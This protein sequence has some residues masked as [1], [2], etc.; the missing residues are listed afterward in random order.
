RP[1]HQPLYLGSLKSNIG[2]TQ[3]AAGVSGV[4]KMVQ[5]IR[6][7]TVPGTLHMTELSRHVDWSAGTVAVPSDAV[8]WPETGRPRRAGVSSFGISG[9]N[10]HLIVE[11][12]PAVEEPARAASGVVVPWVLS[13]RTD[14]AV[15]EQAA[16]LAERVTQSPEIDLASVGLTLA[17][18]RS[19]FERGA[20]VVG[21]DRE[22]LL[23]ALSEVT[24]GRT[25]L[26]ARAGSGVAMLFAG[27]GGQRV[28]MG[29]ELYAAHPVFATAVDD[30]LTAVDKELA[31]FVDHPVRDVLFDTTD[32]GLLDQTVYTQS[33]LFAIEVGLYRLLESWGVRPAWLVGH[34]IGE[35]AAAHVAGVF[36]LEDA[37]RLIAARGRLMQAL[38]DGGVMAAIE[39]T[40]AEVVPLLDN[41]V[42][43]A[44]V[45]G[46][47]SVV[48]SGEHTAVERV[49]AH[50][51]NAGH[52]VKRLKVS[53]AFHSPLME[54]MLDDFAEVV[55]SLTFHAPSIPIVSTVTGLAV[56]PDTLTD[57]AYWV[58]H[59]R[60]TVRF[61]DA[62]THLA[63]HH[64][65]GYVEIGPSGVLVAQTQ[66]ILD[67]KGREGH[68]VLPTL[69][70]GQAETHT[71]LT[72]LGRLYA[73]GTGITP[74]WQTILGNHTPLTDLPTY[75]FQRQRYWL[76]ASDPTAD[77]AALGLAPLGHTFLHGGVE[78]AGGEGAV[79][80]GRFSLDSH[81]W[82]VDHTVLGRVLLPGTAFVELALRAAD[83]M[84][85]ARVE[86]LTLSAPLIVPTDGDVQVQVSVGAADERGGRSLTVHARDDGGEWT[87]HAEGM[88]GAGAVAPA[89]AQ[90][91][92]PPPE[93]VAVDVEALYDTLLSGGYAYGPAF[94]GLRAVWRA[95]D[96]LLAEV[97]LP[98]GSPEG[99]GLHPVLL[100][101][102]LHP[103]VGLAL[104]GEEPTVRLPFAWTGAT[105]HATGASELRVRITPDGEGAGGV[106]ISAVDPAGAPVVSVR[107]LRLLPVPLDR[108]EAA[109]RAVPYRV[110]WLPSDTTATEAATR[111]T[112]S[113]VLI[114]EGA[115]AGLPEVPVHRGLG[116][117]GD[118]APE[119]V[120]FDARGGLD[121]SGADDDRLVADMHAAVAGASGFLWSWLADE[122]YAES[123][124]VV[125]TRGAVA[126]GEGDVPDLSTAP[127][128]GLVRS[129]QAEHPG[130]IVLLDVDGHAATPAA[131]V[132][133]V[134][135]GEPQLAVRAGSVL[136]PRLVRAKPREGEQ[137]AGLSPTGTVLITGGT[138]T[139]GAL[140]AR[141]LV[142]RH[143]ARHLL[144]T[145]RRGP[146]AP[147]ATELAAE[148]TELGAHV[149]I[150]ACDVAD[151]DELAALLAGVPEEHPLTAVV[152]AAGVLAD[153]AFA[154]LTDETFATVLRPKADAAWNLHRLTA[155]ADLAAFFLFSSAVGVMGNAGQ[156]NYGSAN[157]FLDALAQYRA[158]HGLPA[159][160]AAWGLWADEGGMTEAMTQA[161]V[162]RMGRRGL[163]AMST[164]RGL[165][166]F[167]TA[168]TDRDPF[169]VTAVVDTAAWDP[170]S[171]SPV[172]RSLVRGRRRPEAASGAAP[173]RPLEQDLVGR[174]AEEQHDVLLD[175]VRRTAAGVLGHGS[176]DAVPPRTGFLEGG[177][178]SLGAVELRT[179]LN[180]ATGL[181][182]PTTLIFDYPTPDAVADY[183][184]TRL[185]GETTVSVMAELERFEAVVAALASATEGGAERAAVAGRLGE[186]LRRLDSEAEAEISAATNDELFALIDEELQL[187]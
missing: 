95:G 125:V 50:F 107:S 139:L 182:L 19:R 185:V 152:H 3:A 154:S 92:W 59:V 119:V 170:E 133:A 166:L 144:L 42:G 10:A 16:R 113:W 161:D 105:L 45:N 56:E 20:V 97:V 147:G 98:E 160:A 116:A 162:V 141:R 77:A 138:G 115:G 157:S 140:V 1:A 79:L 137:E 146:E 76:N 110:D 94:R 23:T 134:A 9:T 63:D 120:L 81:P 159:T 43:I 66:Q 61:H 67:A 183:L 25:P 122:R 174:P 177:F 71:T 164:A 31:G 130:R 123:T 129:V 49:T 90:G 28:E 167:D 58:H 165:D 124:L 60:T 38:P 70:P 47:A 142:T 4:I 54:P 93:A 187:P 96:E 32:T 27:Q 109:D 73:A 91:S 145:G 62:I 21:A 64:T 18:A 178:D 150:A 114:G 179:R 106:T 117:L 102:A 24:D 12:A 69:R 74:H 85:C 52:R 153:G 111:P 55:K 7:G 40:E 163:A 39:T 6:N 181:R 11:Q 171:G 131:V 156:A 175:L 17:T 83:F 100:D 80:T 2:H 136:V 53:H 35:I 126:A 104:G 173:A 148:L 84:G 103:V 57:P 5:A 176:P 168:L 36:T 108:I 186:L 99:F 158:A 180:L 37:A 151:P 88:L 15:R 14:E 48:V 112:G 184:R 33:A 128:W 169:L 135:G 127:L 41:A 26:V 44:A 8:A 22:E 132:G 87:R 86:D 118:D 75:P 29:R 89:G 68:L 143:G 30:V 13:G 72:T 155:D 65:G 172:V 101:A 78:L 51:E 121:G 82:L 149:R 46:P 34:S